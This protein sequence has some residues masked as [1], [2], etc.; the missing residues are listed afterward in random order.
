VY[1][2]ELLTTTN[3]MAGRRGSVSNL[4]RSE[5]DSGYK[6]SIITF[7]HDLLIENALATLSSRKYGHA[8]CMRHAYGLG[9]D[10]G[11]CS[12]PNEPSYEY[13][14]PGEPESH[15]PIYKIHGS[16]NWVFRTLR[17][18]PSAEFARNDRKLL[19]WKNVTLPPW[20]NTLGGGSSRRDWYL[21]PS[22]SLLYMRSTASSM[23]SSN[24]SL[25][26]PVLI[27]PDPAAHA[28]LWDVLRPRHVHHFHD[29]RDFL[30]S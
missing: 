21:C 9:G 3:W 30:D 15:V 1:A 17:E 26:A 5:L 19:I 24:D 11:T 12:V 7:N 13:S 14:C 2:A 27:N 29:I 4:I 10:T 20:V 22:L 25:R 8:W 6:L 28:A 23:E 16:L 18:Y